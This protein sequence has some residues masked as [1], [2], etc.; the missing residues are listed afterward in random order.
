MFLSSIYRVQGE[1]RKMEVGSWKLEVRNC[2]FQV[3]LTPRAPEKGEG[4]CCDEA[5]LL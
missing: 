5:A 1:R 2:R 4:E 3:D